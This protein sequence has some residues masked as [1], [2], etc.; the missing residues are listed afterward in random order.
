M[1][2]TA[3][4]ISESMTDSGLALAPDALSAPAIIFYALLGSFPTGVGSAGISEGL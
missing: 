3:S 4:D 1:D 2:T